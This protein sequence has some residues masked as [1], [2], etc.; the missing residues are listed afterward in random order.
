[1]TPGPGSAPAARSPSAGPTPARPAVSGTCT[2]V[3]G[4]V[5]AP[6]SFALKYDATAPS[7]SAS[8]ARAPDANGWYNHAVAVSFSGSDSGS[9]IGS[10]SS[11]TSYS[12]PDTS[13][14][15]VSGSCTD[16]AGNS[17]SASTTVRYDATPPAV[18]AAPDRE[19]NA[20]GWYNAPV[21]FRFSGTDALSGIADCDQPKAYS[22]PD[23]GTASAAGACRD[24]AGNAATATATLRYDSTPP[25]LTDLVVQFSVDAATLRWKQPA[26]TADVAVTR[27][28]GRAGPGATTVYHGRA[29]TFRDARLRAGVAY[30]YTLTSR[31]QAG[32]KAT[33]SLTA[34][35]RTLYAPAPNARVKAGAVLAWL[36]KAGA[37]YYNVQ[38]FRNGHKVLTTWTQKPRLTLP[39]RWR[40]AGKTI[41]LQKGRY[42]WYVWPGLGRSADRRY[43]KLLGSSSFRV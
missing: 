11:G 25:K 13:G 4:N 3:A 15:T 19:P 32:N 14:A 8:V 31:D 26:D 5:S 43:G 33:A 22:G 17:G 39:K 41:R 16:A 24:N 1:M 42:R 29:P 20:T 18:T 21:T 28:P 23:S 40:L 30:R 10:C 6:S 2:D 36:P 27:S 9:G 12:G 7:A 37:T 38:I 34:K 35:L